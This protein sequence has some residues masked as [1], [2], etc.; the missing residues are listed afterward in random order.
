M[1]FFMLETDLDMYYSN[2]S[3]LDKID[4]LLVLMDSFKLFESMFMGVNC[5]KYFFELFI[6][7][8]SGFIL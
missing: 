5:S 4:F 7:T 1:L 3:Y 6:T 8:F 2:S